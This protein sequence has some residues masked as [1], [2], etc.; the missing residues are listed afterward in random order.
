M[1][2]A[3]MTIRRVA[4]IFDDRSR[5]ETTGG[6]CLAALR[7]LVAAVHVRPDVLHDQSSSDFDWFLR[8][9]DG[10]DYPVPPQ[11]RPLA[12]WAI[13]THLDFER[14]R[15][16]AASADLVF[17]AQRPGTEALRSAGIAAEWL[18]LACDP[19]V[20]RR[21]DVPER[22]DFAFVGNVF[23]GPRADLLA[24][25]AR[26]YPNHFIGR[27][28]FDDM[29]RLYS[30]ARLTFNRSVG[31]DINMRVFEA[32]ACGSMFLTNDLPAIGQHE[33][34]QDGTHLATYGGVDELLDK[35]AFYLAR[36]EVRQRVATTGQQVVIEKHTYRHRMERILR[37]AAAQP[38]S[39]PVSA[40][41]R[42]RNSEFD[43]GYFE[44]D[45]PELLAQIPPTASDVLDVGCAAGL[46]GQALKRRQPTRVVGIER[47]PRAAGAARSRLDE[48]L[49]SDAE[50]EAVQFPNMTFDVVVCG[51][52]LEHLRE[53]LNF[54]RRVRSWLRPTGQLVASIPNVRHHS[55]VRSLL[56]GDWT[57]ESAGLL[58]RTHLRF[59]TRREIEKLLFRAGFH[60]P[61]VSP[62]PGPGH[63]EWVATGRRGEVR[64]GGLGIGPLDPVEAEEFFTYQW[65]VSATPVPERE[66]GLTSI[67]IPVFNQI[68]YTRQCIDSLRLVT[69]EP[70]ELIVIDNG[71]TDGTSAYLRALADGDDRVRIVRNEANRGFPAA[72]N[73]GIR[74]ALGRQVL[75]LNNDTILPTGWL[76]RL[77]AALHR[78]PDVGLVGPCSNRVSGEQQVPVTYADLTGLDGFAWEWG[79]AHDG[80]MEDTDRLVGF[81]LLIR[82]ELIERVG[83]LDERFGLGNFEDDDFCRRARAAGFRTLIARDAFVH[84]FG[85]QT[86]LALGIDFV[87]LMRANEEQFDRKWNQAELTPAAPPRSLPSSSIR[88]LI[89]AHIALFRDRMG[90]GMYYRYAALAQ[91]PGVTL[92][93]PGMPGYSADMSIEDAVRVA[94]NGVW[95]DAILHGCDPRASGRPLVSGLERVRAITA[96]EIYDSWTFEERQFEFIRR[97]GFTLGLMASDGHHL[98]HYQAACPRTEFV[99]APNAVNTELFRDHG[100]AKAYDIIVY[101]ATN[102][103]VYPLRAR[104]ASLL[105]NQAEFRVRQIPHPGYYPAPA[106]Q[107]D[108]IASERLSREINQAWIGIATS[109]IYRC[110]LEKYLEIAASNA[111]VA[112]DMPDGARSVFGDD[113]IE[114]SLGDSDEAVLEKLRQA[115]A[116]KDRLREMTAAA[117]RR[118]IK[119]FST[120]AFADRVLA[121]LA[122]S[123]ERRSRQ[124]PSETIQSGGGAAVAESA[125]GGPGLKYRVQPGPAGGL[126]LEPAPCVLSVCL[127]VRDNAGTIRACLESIR[128]WVDEMIVVDTGST[129]ETPRIAAEL[130]ARMFHFPWCDDFSAARNES[131]RHARG[132]WVFWMDSDDTIDAVNGRAIRELALGNHPPDLLGFVVRVHFPGPGS[133]NELDF[134]M[135]DHVKLFRNRPDLRFDGRIHEQ[136]LL[137]IRR[138]GGEVAW[139]D[140]FVVHSGYDYSPAGQV[141]KRDRDLRLLN[142]ELSERPNHPFTLFNLGMTYADLGRWEEACGYLEQCL[143]HSIEG[144]S[145][146]RKAYALLTQSWLQRGEL[147]LALQNC[148]QGLKHFP[149]DLEL[150]FRQGIVLHA[151]GQ[152]QEAAAA[153]RRVLGS[154]RERYLSSVD[155]GIGGFKARQNLAAVLAD[156]GDLAG[157][158][159]E[160][161]G[162]VAEVPSYRLGWRGLGE[163][164]LLQ[165]K[166]DAIVE[167]ANRL[168][169]MTKLPGEAALLRG[170]AALATGDRVAARKWLDVA[171]KQCPSDAEAWRQLGQILFEDGLDDWAE[172]V[173]YQ[174]TVLQPESAAAFHN[175]GLVLTQTGRAAAAA[176]ALHRS[177]ELR[178]NSQ[179]T[180]DLLQQILRSKVTDKHEGR[181]AQL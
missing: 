174:V 141:R 30:A 139:T 94:C 159:I 98:R 97:H 138:A 70:F 169:G 17:T 106:A 8:V 144:E 77:L 140:L 16:Q 173:H 147:D 5:P 177:L 49:V 84:H 57:Y 7:N 88:V 62:L 14:C 65:L 81:C 168:D 161:R 28:Y 180:R 112:G 23:P 10:H 18:P 68:G 150:E 160:W 122:D 129:D 20:H 96:I 167:L 162:V 158:E 38:R 61:T 123:V 32:L 13:D 146:V 37:A 74:I 60:A 2:S 44:F 71:S 115:L 128:P 41:D 91:R 134:T 178:P 4:V 15:V 148:R 51:D 82:R 87:G 80:T 164:L 170:R 12:W 39:V 22:F 130:G 166:F 55:V 75:L 181:S 135:V 54:L 142:L 176:D 152:L 76:H 175:L 149:D 105:A 6:Y 50:D 131:L 127:I 43:P 120:D 103:E 92:F 64:I 83:L 156:A 86:F 78:D 47:N 73:Q 109:S 59:F 133:D 26:H 66:W 151:R 21:H 101:G 137:A 143:Q 119:E 1:W 85:G 58:D 25:L 108:V 46:L 11:C 111:L 121:V 72:V 24:R 117:R 48:V 19:T 45:R 155:P 104:L 36:P 126:L 90:K 116:D 27:A 31:D 95:P 179:A 9:D 35:F 29:A 93:G 99:W 3:A 56:A 125:P 157:A 52:I 124:G 69:D 67:V 163:A 132:Q 136:I 79:K 114:L 89:L 33:L 118:V 53:P 110:L 107:H 171:T 154:S 165:S 40:A 172:R 102:P 34:F 100:L 145:Q 153:Y 42:L 113:F 63:A